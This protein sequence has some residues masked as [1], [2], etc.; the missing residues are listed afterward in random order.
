[1]SIETENHTLLEDFQQFLVESK[2][3]NYGTQAPPDL[4]TLLIEL[5]GLKTEVKAE[6]RQ[7]KNTLDTL[8]SALTSMQKDQAEM[9]KK[10]EKLEHQHEETI[11][12]MLMN[13]LDIY[14]SLSLSAD[15]LQR[16]QPVNTLFKSSRK[17]DINFINQIEQGQLMTVKRLN[18]SLRNYQ[19]TK[20]ESKGKLLDPITMHAVETADV[21]A[22]KNGIVLEELRT[23]FLYKKQVLRVAEVKV[24]KTNS[25]Y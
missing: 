9:L 13:L 25:T 10:A 11:K 12:N 7:F 17:K 2:S 8:E 22:Q 3:D 16:F 4:H 14:D 23:G 6:S 5:T 24:N 21:P 1:M 18:K 19:V 15:N 20:I